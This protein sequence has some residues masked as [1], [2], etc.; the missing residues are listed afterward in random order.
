MVYKRFFSIILFLLTI[1]PAQGQNRLRPIT[2]EEPSPSH[3]VSEIPSPVT[4]IRIEDS[5]EDLIQKAGWFPEIQVEVSEGIVVISGKASDQEQV[6][7]LANAADRLPSVIAVINRAEV[8]T[9]SFTDFT[10]VTKELGEFL[11]I[12]KKALPSILLASVLL[13]LFFWLGKYVQ[14]AL[15]RL[16]RHG[17]PNPF[18]LATVTRISMIPIWVVFFYLV[19]LTIGLPRLATSIL[20]GTGI[21]GIVFG[22]AFKGIAENYL[23]GILLAIRSPFTKGD[24][25][26]VDDVMGFV[27]SL[28]MRGTTIVDYDGNQ[29]LIPNTKVVQS[30]VKN[31]SANPL[32]RSSFTVGIGYEDSIKRSQEII[33]DILKDARGIAS[34]PPPKIF[35]ESLGSATVNL[36]VFFWFN[37]KQLPELVARSRAISIAKEA[38][39]A[40]GVSL[41]DEAREIVFADPLK[42]KVLEAEKN[43]ESNNEPEAENRLMDPCLTTEDEE[44]DMTE[45]LLNLADKN[46]LPT[47]SS[48]DNLL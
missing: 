33:K 18:L 48:K 43:Q 13:L 26:Q 37:V 19:L 42:V 17:I 36:K 3:K 15:K 27:Q 44:E 5:L 30:V 31:F 9:P 32:T 11:K 29:T 41:P 40:N 12:A 38:L 1:L 34:D 8:L 6:K 39:M 25:I 2:Q 22:F 45:Q 7:W 24:L 23:S 10:P 21:L 47:N 20:G 14:M 28:N 35:V 4:D 46:S 16:W